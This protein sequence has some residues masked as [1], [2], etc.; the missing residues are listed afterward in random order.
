MVTNQTEVDAVAERIRLYLSD[1]PNAADT[2][3]G[4]ATWWLS[5]N[6][7]RDWINTVRRAIELLA[8]SGEI[9]TKTLPD[10]A[11]TV[12]RSIQSGRGIGKTNSA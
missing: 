11:V 9:T 12:E 6:P 5:G 1:H 3:E 7:S 2:I 10:G 8:E 4:V